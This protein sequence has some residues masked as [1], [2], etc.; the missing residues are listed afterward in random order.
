MKGFKN[1]EKKSEKIF[2]LGINPIPS[3]GEN[4]IA[5]PADE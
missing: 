4:P 5:N 1:F 2:S 3:I